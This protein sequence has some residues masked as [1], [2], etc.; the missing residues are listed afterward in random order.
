M[1]VNVNVVLDIKSTVFER[2]RLD[3]LEI[4]AHIQVDSPNQASVDRPRGV[5]SIC[6]S[7][8][9]HMIVHMICHSLDDAL[10]LGDLRSD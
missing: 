3:V 4:R 1:V 2:Y 9:V 7:P 6:L 10:S 8:R 5:C